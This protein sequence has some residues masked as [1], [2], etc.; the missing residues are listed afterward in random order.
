M[1]IEQIYTGCLAQGAYFIFSNGEAAVI[2]PL[3]E[4]QPYIQKAEKVGAKIK[5]VFET[6]FH[7]DFV[8]GHLDLSEKTGSEIVYGP[9]A[10]TGFKAHI[11][12]DLEEFQIGEI[13]IQALHT[14]G[15]T[16]ESTSYLLLDKNRKP[17]AL[18]S[19][20]TLFIGDVGRPDLA[21]KG[22]LTMEDLAG[23]LYDSLRSKI[24]TLP[25][26]VIVYPAHG[27]GSACGK[28]MS[29]ETSDTLGNQKKFNYALRADM[30]KEEFIKEVTAGLPEPPQYFPENVKMNQEGSESID[31]VMKRG[32][33]ALSAEAFEAKANNY[34]A[35]ILDTRNASDFAKGFIPN[36][37]NIGID[38][39]FAPWV[40][41]LIPDLK[42]NLMI[43]AEPGQEEE[44]VKR[45]ARVGYDF[46]IGYLNGGFD[47]WEKAGKEI[48]AVTSISAAEFAE[49]YKSGKLKVIDVRKPD[50]F[51]TGHIK[52]AENLP[53]DNIND[54]MEEFQKNET[55]Y[56]HCAGGYRSMIASSILKSRGFEDVVNIEGGFG[57]V[58][59]TDVLV[60]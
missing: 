19:G 42:Q 31:A 52:G 16:L 2:D 11:A 45:L 51:E 36:S 37:I 8:S 17:T 53:L 27:A 50:E 33:Q 4:V 49:H 59:K 56:I 44:V 41:A 9:G 60:E 10:K 34:G 23:I 32:D 24:M 18:F 26:D 54:L 43:I 25:D 30:T 29:K 38:G 22:D 46:A 14:P 13:I 40:G 15:H 12:K 5:Y 57:A 35:L 58:L 48:D 7:A 21:Q 3:R 55:L 28:N 39:G 6:H 1:K 47:V 20:D